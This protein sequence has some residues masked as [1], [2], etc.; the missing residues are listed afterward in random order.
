PKYD[1]KRFFGKAKLTNLYEKRF[2]ELKKRE[3]RYASMKEHL[4]NVKEVWFAGGHCDVGGGSVP[5]ETRANL[6]RIPLRWMVRE[7]FKA[8]TGIMFDVDRLEKIGLD[9]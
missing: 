2:K 3:E 6:A 1:P 9:S 4:T 8:N 7:C 5:N